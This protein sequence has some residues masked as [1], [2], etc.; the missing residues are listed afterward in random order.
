MMECRQ[1]PCILILQAAR[2]IKV[3]RCRGAHHTLGRCNG[4]IDNEARYSQTF[5]GKLT[6]KQIKRG[7]LLVR[8]MVAEVNLERLRVAYIMGSMSA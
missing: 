4:V 5:L 7:S 2:E 8:P 1:L 6:V 3:V